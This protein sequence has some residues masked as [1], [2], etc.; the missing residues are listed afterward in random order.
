[1]LVLAASCLS[2]ESAKCSKTLILKAGVQDGATRLAPAAKKRVQIMMPEPEPEA[3]PRKPAAA[4]KLA[5]SAPPTY[6]ALSMHSA[7]QLSM[8]HILGL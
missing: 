5:L 2:P 1:M 6:A 8:E 3:A 4:A 7:D